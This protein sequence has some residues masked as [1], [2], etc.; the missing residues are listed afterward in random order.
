MFKQE[1]DAVWAV[2]ESWIRRH[3]PFAAII[4][5]VAIVLLA[6][7]VLGAY[8]MVSKGYEVSF[9]GRAWMLP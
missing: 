6:G 4:S 8:E 7:L 1:Q 9:A 2:I 3:V 5:I